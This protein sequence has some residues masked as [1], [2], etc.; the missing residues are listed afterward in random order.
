MRFYLVDR[1]LELEPPKRIVAVKSLSL[2]E[3]YLA[4]HFPAYPVLPGVMMLEALVQS[5]AWLVRASTDFQKTVIL[6]REAQNVRYGA[7]VRPGGQLLMEVEAVGIGPAASRFRAA[8]QCEGQQAVQ[9]RLTLEHLN[10][11]DDD[12]GRADLDA[13]LRAF[14]RQRFKLIGG[15]QALAARAQP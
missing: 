15:P 12:P 1:I 7:F 14:W 9:A 5:A 10:I 2:A 13:G 3:E 6:L 11:A 8:G 4:D